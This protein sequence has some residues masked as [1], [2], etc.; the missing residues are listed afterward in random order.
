M[1][2]RLAQQLDGVEPIL[3][4]AGNDDVALFC[5]DLLEPFTDDG[6][7]IGVLDALDLLRWL[8]AQSLYIVW[9]P[10]PDPSAHP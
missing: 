2:A 5:Q 8:S 9:S 3:G 4:L 1:A 10:T 7:V 6:V